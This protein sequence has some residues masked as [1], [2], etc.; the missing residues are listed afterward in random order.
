MIHM[1]MELQLG[2]ALPSIATTHHVR[3]FEFDLNNSYVYEPKD[4]DPSSWNINSYFGSSA[5]VPGKCST[6]NSSNGNKKRSCDD[7]FDYEQVRAVPPRT[8]PLFNWNSR[9]PDDEDD[10]R[11]LDNNSSF[12]SNKTVDDEDGVHV[13]GWPPIKNWRKKLCHQQHHIPGG[14]VKNNQAVVANNGSACG[15]RQSNSMY[16]KVKMEGVAIARKIDLTLYDSFETL[17]NTLIGMFGLWLEDSYDYQLT[18]QDREGD[19]LIAKDVP[20]RTFIQ[21]VQRLNLSR[22]GG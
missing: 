10:P 21:T 15:G 7:A 5:S 8:L 12:G 17:T 6:T 11:D 14:R 2:L 13:V 19:W 18:Y 1:M 9:Y 3:G 20:W 4:S 22:S 16:V